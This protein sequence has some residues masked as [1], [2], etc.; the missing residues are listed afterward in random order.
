MKLFHEWHLKDDYLVKLVY[1]NTYPKQKQRGF[2]LLKLTNFSWGWHL[3]NLRTSSLWKGLNVN[4]FC[5]KLGIFAHFTIPGGSQK[6]VWNSVT[7]LLKLRF[8]YKV[9]YPQEIDWGYIFL[10]QCKLADLN[11]QMN[12]CVFQNLFTK[13][14]FRQS[15]LIGCLEGGGISLKINCPLTCIEEK[16]P[17]TF[18]FH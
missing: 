13:P 8:S 11:S 2:Y 17:P 5:E 3:I 10:K 12:F 18:Y 7:T 9:M 16:T 14:N 15:I 4:S 6:Q 1:I